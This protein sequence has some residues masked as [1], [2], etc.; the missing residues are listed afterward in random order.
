MPES[1]VTIP[2]DT[3]EAVMRAVN[4]LH[5]GNIPAKDRHHIETANREVEQVRAMVGGGTYAPDQ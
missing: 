4:R 5:I 2:L 3:M 1:A